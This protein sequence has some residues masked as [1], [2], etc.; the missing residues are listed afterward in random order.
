[1]NFLK[2]SENHFVRKGQLGMVRFDHPSPH[3]STVPINAAQIMQTWT[4]FRYH[5]AFP[6]QCTHYARTVGSGREGPDNNDKCD[7]CKPEG[8]SLWPSSVDHAD[9]EFYCKE[10]GIFFCVQKTHSK[11]D[12]RGTH[13]SDILRC[14]DNAVLH[15]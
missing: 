1:M 12:F 15:N 4:G 2:K 9:G 7:P 6:A 14:F 11:S 3:G 8:T 13:Q 5:K 10:V